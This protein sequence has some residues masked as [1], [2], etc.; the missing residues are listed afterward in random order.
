MISGNPRLDLTA[1]NNVNGFV[2]PGDVVTFEMK[3]KNTGEV[4]VKNAQLIQKLYDQSDNYLGSMLFDLGTIEA[5]KAGR[6][7]FGLKVPEGAGGGGYKTIA[8]V[9]GA[10]PNGNQITSGDAITRFDVRARYVT[11]VD[12]AENL[13]TGEVLGANTRGPWCTDRKQDIWIFVMLLLTSTVLFANRVDDKLNR[14]YADKK[15]RKL[16]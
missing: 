12:Q 6:L 8:Y 11:P 4:P 1:T 16:S 7:G 10:A 14:A 13:P 15:I 2:Y 5:G 9:T 3:V